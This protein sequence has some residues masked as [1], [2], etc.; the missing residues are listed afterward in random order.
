MA[1]LA[2]LQPIDDDPYRH[3]R[4]VYNDRYAN[5]AAGKRN[6]Q[7]PRLAFARR[8]DVLRGSDNTSSK[9][10]RSALRGRCLIAQTVM[11]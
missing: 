10:R 4:E 6:W 8:R 2:Q 9:A 7:L 5:F 1:K 11:P 3:A